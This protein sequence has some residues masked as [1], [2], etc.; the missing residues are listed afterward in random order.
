MDKVISLETG[1]V[2]F[3]GETF[4]KKRHRAEKKLAEKQEKMEED[5][6]QENS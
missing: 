5:S 1:S 4:D 6:K 3:N 2:L